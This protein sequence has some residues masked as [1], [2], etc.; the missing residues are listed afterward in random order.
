MKITT[1]TG[2]KGETRLYGG[3]KVHKSSAYIEVL[4]ELDSLHAHLGWAKLLVP[5]EITP[6]LDRV[7][8]DVYRMLSI[9]GYEMKSP[10]SIHKI[11]KEDTE[12]LE[13]AAEEYSKELQNL[14]KFIEPGSSE[15]S[16]RLNIARTVAR[17][18]EHNILSHH[19][20][21]EIPEE[22]GKYLNRLSDFLFALAFH[23]EAQIKTY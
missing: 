13:K 9:V 18:V 16:A 2:D 11:T 10:K 4:G 15:I 19:E 6:V 23:F 7:Q 22:M 1:K 17:K 12:F 20:E 5:K 8:K 14:H 3:R 21:I